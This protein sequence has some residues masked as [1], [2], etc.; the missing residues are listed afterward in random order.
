[1]VFPVMVLDSSFL[2]SL[3]LPEDSNNLKAL[4]LF[5][6]HRGDE[7]LL[8]DIVLFETLTILAYKKSASFAKD[9]Y[10][11]LLSNRKLHLLYLNENE[12]K[13][14]LESFLEQNGKLSVEDISVIHSCKKALA[15]PLAFDRE[16]LKAV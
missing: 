13:E 1:M 9:A 4:S 15:K 8:T 7:M 6:K 11:D 12:K 16:I 3:F 14:I 10:R 2:V 5:E